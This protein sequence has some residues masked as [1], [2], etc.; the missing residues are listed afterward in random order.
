MIQELKVFLLR[1]NVIDLAIAVV[2]GAAF[3]T[4]VNTFVEQILNPLIGLIVG[5]RDLS[6]LALR[7]G[8]GEDPTVF[9]FGIL[10]NAIINFLL[11]GLVLFLVVK[12]ANRATQARRAKSEVVPQSVVEE[13]PEDVLLLR[14][15]RDT[16]RQDRPPAT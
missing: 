2:I 13:T 16:L 10:L 6:G 3:T 12:A 9:G 1:G 5:Q 8:E 7:I 4:V 11:V 15:I 14:E